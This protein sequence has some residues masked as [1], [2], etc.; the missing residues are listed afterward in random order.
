MRLP[1]LLILC[2]C[3]LFITNC[4][5]DK[6]DCFDPT[7]PQC[8]NYDPCYGQKPV[9]ADIELSQRVEPFGN[10]PITK[11][12][13]AEDSIFPTI[14][15]RFHCPLDGAK[16]TWTLGAETITSQTFERAFYNVPFGEYT[17]KLTVEKA[18]NKNCFP[19]DDGIDTYTKKFKIVPV[20]S[21]A[22]LGLFKGK[23][24][25]LPQK[26][27]GLIS[28]RVFTNMGWEDS[29]GTSLFRFT[30]LSSEQDTL[31]GKYIYLSNTEIINDRT[32]SLGLANGKFKINL[33]DSTVI[34]NY[35]LDNIPYTFRGRRI[36]K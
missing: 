8:K 18:P 34:M 31:I 35:L 36:S 7:N 23:W 14:Q 4:K 5:R 16:Y 3:L 32:S 10:D 25:N 1:L 27:S 33:K 20:C 21:L 13:F 29:C 15:I 11:L 12:Y 9:T 22:I 6:E 28:I 17:V 30:N 19:A 26:D 2:A 24:D